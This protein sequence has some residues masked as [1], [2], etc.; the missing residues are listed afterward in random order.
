MTNGAVISQ[1]FTIIYGS[2]GLIVSYLLPVLG[3][4]GLRFSGVVESPFSPATLK[5]PK[6]GFSQSLVEIELNPNCSL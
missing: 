2:V 5:S 3:P 1:Y 6:N 4:T